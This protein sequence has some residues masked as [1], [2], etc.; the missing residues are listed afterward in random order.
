M[1]L[2]LT[3]NGVSVP[4]KYHTEDQVVVR[5]P[6]QVID[7][8]SGFSQMIT[9]DGLF[10][11]VN[12]ESYIETEIENSEEA[13]NPELFPDSISFKIYGSEAE[14]YKLDIQD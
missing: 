4:E 10:P 1:S 5:T 2:K 13:D 7:I 8:S 9:S 6:F 11:L 3:T 12:E 14:Q